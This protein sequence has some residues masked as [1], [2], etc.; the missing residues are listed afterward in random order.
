M[1]HLTRE[2]ALIFG[3][4]SVVLLWFFHPLSAF[5]PNGMI[6]SCGVNG[7]TFP[8]CSES[9]AGYARMDFQI[10]LTEWLGVLIVTG[11]L[12][13]IAPLKTP[14]FSAAEANVSTIQSEL[15]RLTASLAKGEIDFD[16]YDAKKTG[17]LIQ[18]IDNQTSL[19]ASMIMHNALAA[20]EIIRRVHISPGQIS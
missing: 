9:A 4:V 3:L 16:E 5:Y 7:W 11:L 19:K 15:H 13:K 14:D 8:T 1:K 17:K 12:Y 2:R 6:R 20:P 10:L 18:L